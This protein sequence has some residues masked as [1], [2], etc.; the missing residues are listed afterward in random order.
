ML[1]SHKSAPS[2]LEPVQTASTTVSPFGATGNTTVYSAW[3][4]GV[5]PRWVLPVNARLIIT[6]KWE[7]IA[8]CS[9]EADHD[10]GCYLEMPL[11]VVQGSDVMTDNGGRKSSGFIASLPP[12]CR[13]PSTS[14]A[15]CF[16]PDPI[17]LVGV[18]LCFGLN[19]HIN[20][21]KS[22][23]TQTHRLSFTLRRSSWNCL[24]CTDCKVLLFSFA[25]PTSCTFHCDPI[26]LLHSSLKKSY[27]SFLFV[28]FQHIASF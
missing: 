2:N 22:S 8:S 1:T 23:K 19:S 11:A 9:A 13:S 4:E 21:G 17:R 18:F 27:Y 28:V 15:V 14:L 10:S 12:W 16:P 20:L 26:I 25:S 3:R 5:K 7:K 6:Y 24:A